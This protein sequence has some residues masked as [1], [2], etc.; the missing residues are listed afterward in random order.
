MARTKILESE[1]LG[2]DAKKTL[3]SGSPEAKPKIAFD[4]R[5][6]LPPGMKAEDML[7]QASPELRASLEAQIAESRAARRAQ[8]QETVERVKATD[9][10]QVEQLRAQITPQTPHGK[11]TETI[12]ISPEEAERVRKGAAAE[13][14]KKQQT[15]SLWSKLKNLWG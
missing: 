6:R 4:S 12:N 7:A 8:L 2:M 11:F 9:Q 14:K 5:D 15:K 10:V 13:G 1:G 3:I